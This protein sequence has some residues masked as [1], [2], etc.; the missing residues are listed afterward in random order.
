LGLLA[1]F[2]GQFFRSVMFTDRWPL[3]TDHTFC[4]KEDA[5]TSVLSMPVLALNRVFAPIH[6]IDVRRALSLLVT[7]SAEVVDTDDPHLATYDF[8]SWRELSALKEEFEVEQHGWVG[9]VR[10]RVAAPN[11]VRLTKFDRPRHGIRRRGGRRVGTRGGVPGP[12]VPLNR[13]NIY[14]RDASICQYC[15]K[16]FPSSELSLDHVQPKSRGGG[17]TWENLV[18][19]C[20]SCNAR[21]ADK[22][23]AE[24]GMRLIRVP[25]ALK[26][27]A[28]LIRVQHASWAQ[29]VDE[30][31]W[32]VE[33]KG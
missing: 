1:V 22:T 11:V 2:G 27:P 17:D 16:K 29:F 25:R 7:G 4:G 33:L 26:T 24:A 5:M 13:R 3:T 15:G 23:P 10:G 30:A 9:L 28:Q 20:T 32:N 14:H 21:K 6:V 8:T 18:C 31:Y 19:A 12:F